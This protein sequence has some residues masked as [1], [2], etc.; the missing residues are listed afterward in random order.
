M[1]RELPQVLDLG[2]SENSRAQA[3]GSGNIVYGNTIN[4]SP[5]SVA[6]QPLPQ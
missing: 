4:L 3:G 1:I 5:D 2:V 6:W